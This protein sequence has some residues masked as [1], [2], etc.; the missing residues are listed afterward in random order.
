MSHVKKASSAV[1]IWVRRYAICSSVKWYWLMN[2]STSERPAKT[3][4]WPL[5]GQVRKYMSKIAG[6][7][8]L[9]AT[10]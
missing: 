1:G 8:C 5:K 6:V 10:Q 4:N 9:P 3:Q 2:A 7:P